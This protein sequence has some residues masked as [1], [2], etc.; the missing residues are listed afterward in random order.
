MQEKCGIS[1]SESPKSFKLV[2][3]SGFEF[4]F[5]VLYCTHM[6]TS[7][8]MTFS[9]RIERSTKK[10]LEKLAKSTGRSR[11]YLAAQ[12]ID[13]YLEINE[14]QVDGIKKAIA[15]LDAGKGIPHEKVVKWV[16]SLGTKKELPMPR[17]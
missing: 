6:N 11:A 16:R 2:A 10:R 17:A 9:V 8:S 7:D 15:E 12:A 4:Y 13:G 3:Q 14:W 1:T 5:N